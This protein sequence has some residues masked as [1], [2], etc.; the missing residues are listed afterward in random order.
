MGRRQGAQLRGI[1][2][3]GKSKRES[4]G[5]GT[6]L[7]N[8]RLEQK[9]LSCPINGNGMSIS[10]HTAFPLQTIQCP[11]HSAIKINVND[12][13]RARQAQCSPVPLQIWS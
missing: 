3:R 6:R 13:K 10:S 4:L 12:S 8:H 1:L 7:E 11:H 9:G 5:M 2:G